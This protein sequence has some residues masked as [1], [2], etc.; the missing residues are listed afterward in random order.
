MAAKGDG[1]RVCRRSPS[2]SWIETL[3]TQGRSRQHPQQ[4]P[5]AIAGAMLPHLYSSG[6]RPEW[7]NPAPRS[8]GFSGAVRQAPL[9]RAAATSP[10]AGPRIR[11]GADWSQGDH[12]GWA[13]A[14]AVRPD[15]DEGARAALRTGCRR[16]G[17]RLAVGRRSRGGA[18]RVPFAVPVRGGRDQQHHL[19]PGRDARGAL[20]ADVRGRSDLGHPARHIG[21]RAADAAAW[22]CSRRCSQHSTT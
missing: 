17:V 16:R 11:A 2:A 15:G 4:A 5:D 21:A 7:L 13:L 10:S 14:P 12:A 9:S 1:S 22:C 6:L 19:P 18:S 20:A 8:D 3:A